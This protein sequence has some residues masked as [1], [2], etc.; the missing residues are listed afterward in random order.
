MPRFLRLTGCA[1]AALGAAAMIGCENN[2]VSGDVLATENEELRVRLGDLE[3]QLQDCNAQRSSLQ[4]ENSELASSLQAAMDSGT[5]SGGGS[6]AFSDSLGTI[7]GTTVYQSGEGIVVAV[8]GDVLFASGQA[9]LK[10]AARTSLDRIA[11]VIKRDYPGNAVRVEGYTDS[12][13]IRKSKWASNE[14][15]SAER[16]LAVEKQL[17]SRGIPNERIY[18]AAFGP[19]KAKGTKSASRRVEIVILATPG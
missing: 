8:A 14:Q 3:R 15:L 10:S 19:A 4:S 9:T 11:D 2:T 17:V 12:D 5:A 13:P 6:A 1:L 18:S 7:D 16:A